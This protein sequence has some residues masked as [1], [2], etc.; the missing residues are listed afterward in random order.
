MIKHRFVAL[1]MMATSLPAANID[2]N[3]GVDRRFAA[4]PG[5]L[6]RQGPSV[7]LRFGPG[8]VATVT[9]YYFVPRRH[10]DDDPMTD[11]CGVSIRSGTGPAQVVTT[12]GIGSTWYAECGKLFAIG[13]LPALPGQARF[14][15]IN[16]VSSPNATVRGASILVRTEGRWTLDEQ[17]GNR[18]SENMPVTIP[19]LRRALRARMSKTR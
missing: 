16:N 3:N 19:A 18:L 4:D 11:R 10:T 14:A 6:R 9:S 2:T 1:A 7:Q 8:D 13:T 5:S 12:V 15:V 17:L